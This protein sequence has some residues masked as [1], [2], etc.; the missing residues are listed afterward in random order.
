MNITEIAQAAKKASISL[1]AAQ[2]AVK[3]RALAE[4]AE[5]LRQRTSAIISANQ[6]DLAAA[7]KIISPGPC[8]SV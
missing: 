1:A 2:T 3:N 5:S 8:S 7:E 4:I 6:Q